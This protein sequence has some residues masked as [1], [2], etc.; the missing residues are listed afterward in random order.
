MAVKDFMQKVDEAISQAML[1]TGE[2]FINNA[3]QSV[4]QSIYSRNVDRKAWDLTGNLRSSIG[5]QVATNSGRQLAMKFPVQA[6]SGS[7]RADGKTGADAGKELAKSIADNMSSKGD[8]L[9]MVAGME[10]AA[11]VESKGFDVISN[12]TNTAKEAFDRRLRK[13]LKM[14]AK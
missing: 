11:A 14:A 1:Y 9:V 10:Y 7:E 13:T 12:S 5:F 3:R 6:A 8:V 4:T 2:E